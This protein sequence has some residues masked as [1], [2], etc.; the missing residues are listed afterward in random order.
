MIRLVMSPGP[1]STYALFY[2][3]ARRG[4]SL[5]WGSFAG[6]GGGGPSGT[7][8]PR[9]ETGPS[10]PEPRA[11]SESPAA[12]V[13]GRKLQTHEEDDEDR[14][15]RERLAATM[16]LMGVNAPAENGSPHLLSPNTTGQGIQRSSSAQSNV[17]A[18]SSSA[19]NVRPARPVSRWSSFFGR[20]ASAEPASIE[21]T[22]GPA[23]TIVESPPLGDLADTIKQAHAQ[24]KKEERETL[25]HNKNLTEA[26]RSVMDII[27]S[28]PVKA[29]HEVK[30]SVDSMG[31]LED[32]RKPMTM[33]SD[34]ERDGEHKPK[35]SI[36]T[37]FDV[38]MNDN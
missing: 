7:P 31:S 12:R 18:T 28:R 25:R 15:E 5:N 19:N 38:S 1:S 23:E 11:G 4:L 14:V 22:P 29:H 24:R 17:S 35:G 33:Q 3:Q 20:S 37:L 21:S 6:F 2:W 9:T 30:K 16:K 27:A 8:S 10:I 34:S 13:G 26:P 36:S 32:M